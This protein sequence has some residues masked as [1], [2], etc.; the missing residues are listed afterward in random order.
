MQVRH[1]RRE[2]LP[3]IVEVYNSTVALGNVTA[4]TEPV[5]VDSRIEWFEGHEPER[6]PLWVATDDGGRLIGWLSFSPFYG[7]PA[8]RHT[9]EMS[10]YLAEA[11]RGRGFGR[12][13]LGRAVEAARGL[14][15]KV[16][17]G[18]IWRQNVASMRLFASCGFAEWG[19]LPRVAEIGGREFDTVIMGRRTE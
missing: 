5:S 3:A 2:D 19:C 18:F 10:I 7:R 12:V 9:A 14:G 4:D 13:L 8:Y 17:L 1:A 6:H 11:A 16:L 15:F